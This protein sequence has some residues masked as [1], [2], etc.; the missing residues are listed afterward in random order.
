[1]NSLL[2][3]RILKS[4][5]LLGLLTSFTVSLAASGDATPAPDFT[6][7]SRTGENIKLSEL[8]G[9]VVMVN[10]WASWCGPCRQEMPLLQQLYDRY[11]GMGFTLLGVNVDEQ[12]AAAQKMLKEIPVDFPI[13]YDSSNKV[14][15]QYQVKAMPS[16]FMV[17]R[18]GNIRHLHQGYK[19]GYED[20]Y[21]QQIRA[22]LK[23]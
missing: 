1:M 4:T 16:T 3:K 13:L 15:K 8:R 10:F 7:K 20:D 22:L 12:P 17:D 19:P 23:E 18:D 9:N 11:Q 6:L 14:S 2:L 21:Q 5:L